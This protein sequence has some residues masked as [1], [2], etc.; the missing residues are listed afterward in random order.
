ML[1]PHLE[2]GQ[3]S[4]GRISVVA[5]KH[6]SAVRSRGSSGDVWNPGGQGAARVSNEDRR[7][8]WRAIGFSLNAHIVMLRDVA[9]IDDQ[10]GAALL[11]A[12]DGVTRGD[13]A[14][15]DGSLA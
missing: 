15:V 9:I 7:A 3:A 12:I 1:R 5:S 6:S 2:P 14:E 4:Q 13:P 8:L 11:T 10:I